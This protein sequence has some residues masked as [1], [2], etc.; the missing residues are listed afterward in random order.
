MDMSRINV[1]IDRLVLRGFD[2]GDGEAVA[3]GLK[4][5]LSHVLSDPM[6]RAQWARWGR[7]PVLRLHTIGLEAGISGR[8]KFG[9][10]MA[11]QIGKGLK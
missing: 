8:R 10:G 9:A 6:T 5:E 4:S 11:R 2:P 1:T 3:E 7:T